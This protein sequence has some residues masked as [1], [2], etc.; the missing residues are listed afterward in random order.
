MGSGTNT[1][2]PSFL[3]S[4]FFPCPQAVLVGRF[5]LLPDH[6]FVTFHAYKFD[7]CLLSPLFF[8]FENDFLPCTGNGPFPVRGFFPSYN[9]KI[10]V[11]PRAGDPAQRPAS[12]PH[13]LVFCPLSPP[14]GVGIFSIVSGM[15][16]P[17]VQRPLVPSF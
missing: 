2:D 6:F 16:V 9:L 13:G 7:P 12:V 3:F 1:L 15:R 4:A 11:F 17:W 10:Q 5:T 8:C 14:V